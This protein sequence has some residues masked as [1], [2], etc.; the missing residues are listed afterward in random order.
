[1]KKTRTTYEK[2]MSSNNRGLCSY[3]K[4]PQRACV[5]SNQPIQGCR[6]NL[7]TVPAAQTS[8]F[9]PFKQL[10]L[11]GDLS[12]FPDHA[13]NVTPHCHCSLG[14]HCAVRKAI[15]G[16]VISGVVLGKGSSAAEKWVTAVAQ[17]ATETSSSGTVSKR[18]L[19]I[20]IFK[21][22]SRKRWFALSSQGSF[23][24]NSSV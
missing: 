12:F 17:K 13:E 15:N 4:L 9:N 23:V 21:G 1:M 6:I 22:L 18:V 19:Q 3:M 5:C 10:E 20:H 24:V 16:N 11:Q 2:Q 7:Q 14:W 8:I